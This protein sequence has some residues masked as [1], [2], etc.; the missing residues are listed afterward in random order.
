[1]M[2]ERQV[3]DCLFRALAKTS[4]LALP[5]YTP[6]GWWECDF[7]SVSRAGYFSEHE[8]KLTKGDFLRDAEKREPYAWDRLGGRP[9]AKVPGAGKH[10]LLSKR[11][12]RGPVHFWYCLPT[13]LVPLADIPPWAGV[14][15]IHGHSAF[16]KL[17]VAREAQRLHN[18]PLNASIISHARS[19]C[20]W[21]FWNERLSKGKG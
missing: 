8:I 2:T 13:D 14:K 16:C 20:F 4:Q 9:A 18:E 7:F 21:R 3:Q 1:M 11:S 12:V 19:V 10:E 15:W 17:T 5:N 6:S